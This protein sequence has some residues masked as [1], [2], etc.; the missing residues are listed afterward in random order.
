MLAVA[1]KVEG[2]FVELFEDFGHVVAFFCVGEDEVDRRLSPVSFPYFSAVLAHM[3]CARFCAESQKKGRV[4]LGV[5]GDRAWEFLIEGS[6]VADMAHQTFDV[7]RQGLVWSR[8]S[9]AGVA[10]VV[11]P[12]SVFVVDGCEEPGEDPKLLVPCVAQDVA[13]VALGALAYKIEQQVDF[14][15][16]KGVGDDVGDAVEAGVVVE[17]LSVEVDVEF[18]EGVEQVVAEFV[19][20]G[21]EAHC[22]EDDFA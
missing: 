1:S 12:T 20:Q 14:E 4:C 21:V 8:V 16:L 7:L 11:E 15:V 10:P 6:K 22:L 3:V 2:A 13:H 5:F 9:H 18:V 19:H 17:A